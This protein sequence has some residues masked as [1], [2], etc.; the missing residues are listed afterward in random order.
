M[1]EGVEV[2][3]NAAAGGGSEDDERTRAVESAFDACGVAAH[4]SV[5]HGGDEMTELARRALT[6]GTRAVVA[7]GGDG[8]VGSVAGALAGTDRPLGVL[9]LGTLNHFAKDLHI[10]LTLEEAARNICEGQV[11]P[12]DVGEVNGHIFVNNSSLGLYPL[13]VRRRE[14][15]QERE[16]S[17]KWPAFLRAALAVLRRYPFMNVRLDADGQEIVRKTPFIFVGN[18]EYQVENLQMGARSCLDAGRLSLYVAH[19][20]GR[21]G[22]LRLALSALFG[23]LRE[24]HDFDALCAREIWVETRRPKRLPVATDGEVL[25]LSTPLHYRIR[26]GALKV[27]V[28]KDVNREET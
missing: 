12:V 4:V 8:T 16:G 15:L 25:L 24:A 5:A 1:S 17:G 6:N 9:P 26:P 27:I 2:I 19:R 14:K 20:T 3:I 7:G 23:R 10:P 18:N 21:L 22:L 13:I 11:R 28:P